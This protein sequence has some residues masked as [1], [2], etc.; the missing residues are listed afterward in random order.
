MA[1]L[2]EE[3]SLNA[4]RLAE[5]ETKKAK[6]DLESRVDCLEVRVKMAEDLLAKEPT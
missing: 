4:A 1:K 2:I 3:E 6:I 5:E